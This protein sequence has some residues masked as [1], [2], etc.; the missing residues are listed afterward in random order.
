[1]R[2]QGLDPAAPLTLLLHPGREAL[3]KLYD[4]TEF[5]SRSFP[6]SLLLEV[7]GEAKR[8]YSWRVLDQAEPTSL[9]KDGLR[10]TRQFWQ[11]QDRARMLTLP[12]VAGPSHRIEVVTPDEVIVDPS[13]EPPPP[14][15]R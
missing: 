8:D 11:Y 14:R 15:K 9:F 2:Q 6:N 1:M 4:G 10:Q 13:L 7:S 12:V 5:V 3:F